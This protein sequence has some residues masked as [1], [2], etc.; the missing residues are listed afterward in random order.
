MKELDKGKIEDPGDIS[1]VVYI[2]MDKKGAWKFEIAKEM[3]AI[4]FNID[5]NK[6]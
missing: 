2:T 3:R 6:I 5:L 1:G 4:G